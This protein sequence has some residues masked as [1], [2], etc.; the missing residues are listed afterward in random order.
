MMLS[1]ALLSKTNFMSVFKLK[2]LGTLK[3]FLGIEIAPAP[4]GIFLYQC[5]YTLDILNETSMLGSKPFFLPME[6]QHKLSSDTCDPVPDPGR[7]RRLIG[8]LSYLTINS[9]EIMYPVHILNKFM[10]DPWQGH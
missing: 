9:L 2:D 10:Q 5:K 3:Y 8:H 6:Q 7:Y 1:V 4:E